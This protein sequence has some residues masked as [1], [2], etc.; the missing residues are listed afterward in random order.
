MRFTEN[1]SSVLIGTEVERIFYISCGVKMLIAIVKCI[2][3][4]YKIRIISLPVSL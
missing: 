3:N 2:Y 4:W 1:Y